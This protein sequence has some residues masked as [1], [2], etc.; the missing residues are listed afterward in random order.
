MSA[1][2]V[3][4]ITHPIRMGFV[5]TAVC[6][7]REWLAYNLKEPRISYNVYYAKYILLFL[8]SIFSF[9]A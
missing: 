8:R 4:S 6:Q 2:M 5:H 1:K 7:L 3:I 9:F